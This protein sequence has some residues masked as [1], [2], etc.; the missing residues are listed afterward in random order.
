MNREAQVENTLCP[1]EYSAFDELL[2]GRAL[3]IRAIR[4]ADK[5]VLKEGMKHLS[6]ESRYFRFFTPKSDLSGPELKYFTE[7]DFVHHVGLLACV[8]NEGQEMPVGVGRYIRSDNLG[9]PDVA[10]IA[11]A[12]EEEYQGHGVATCLLNH[13]HKIAQAQ[14]LK[15]FRAHV[16]CDNT[17]MLE[18][19][20]GCGLAKTAHKETAGVI[21]IHFSI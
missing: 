6:Q 3:L 9:E 17:K 11:F 20:N 15:Q 5:D 18:V 7:L 12:V 10:E 2:D 4:P 13:L 8:F 1:K 14:G 21:E 19:F 16:R